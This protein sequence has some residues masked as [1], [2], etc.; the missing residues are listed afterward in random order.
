MIYGKAYC[1]F[2]ESMFL[3][4]RV[5]CFIW[6]PRLSVLYYYCRGDTFRGRVNNLLFSIS[7]NMVLDDIL[8]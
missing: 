3:C 1:N 6:I 5:G 4:F 7:L 2:I 8:S